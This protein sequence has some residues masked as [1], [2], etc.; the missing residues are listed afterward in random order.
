MPFPFTNAVDSVFGAASPFGGS[1]TT[2]QVQEA[3][4]EFQ[5]G[6]PFAVGSGAKASVPNAFG[7]DAALDGLS[8]MLPL[9]LIGGL[10]IWAIRR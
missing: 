8:G 4:P 3:N 5:I 7:A 9:L 10:I 2:S 1:E 6:S